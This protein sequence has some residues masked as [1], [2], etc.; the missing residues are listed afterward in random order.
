MAL[1][2]FWGKIWAENAPDRFCEIPPDTGCAAKDK[3]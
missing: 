2:D 3:K 1:K